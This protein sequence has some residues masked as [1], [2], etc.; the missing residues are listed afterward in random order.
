MSYFPDLSPY[1]YHGFRIAD[2]VVNIG[3]LNNKHTYSQGILQNE[4]L[5]KLW[6]FT[7]L[8]LIRMRGFHIC[9]LCS[10]RHPS[11]LSVL[12]E[13]ETLYLGTAE[14]RVFGKN[15]KIYAAPNMLYHYIKEHLYNPPEEFITAVLCGPAPTSAEYFN[16]LKQYNWL[17]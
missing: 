16:L 5:D 10:L 4:F 2:N 8:N 1:S 11:P 14:I 13:G 15:G 17:P 7:R 6:E 9:N 3:W 12:R